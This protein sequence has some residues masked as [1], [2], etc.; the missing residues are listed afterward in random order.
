MWVWANCRMGMIKV[1]GMLLSFLQCAGQHPHPHQRAIWFE[2]STAGK[3]TLTTAQRATGW[4]YQ[5]LL[6]IHVPADFQRTAE[7]KEDQWLE[8]RQRLIREL[9]PES[10]TAR[11]WLLRRK[12]LAAATKTLRP[13]PT[14]RDHNP[15]CQTRH[16][17]KPVQPCMSVTTSTQSMSCGAQLQGCLLR[18][19]YCKNSEKMTNCQG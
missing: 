12:L 7:T 14:Y 19:K 10:V 15:S 5:G 9:R 3:P 2:V 17:S 11:T 1:P 4:K 13:V 16:V 6:N 8:C 18:S